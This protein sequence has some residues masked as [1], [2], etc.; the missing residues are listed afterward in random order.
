MYKFNS[1]GINNDKKLLFDK[2]L[3]KEANK[4]SRLLSCIRRIIIIP[5]LSFFSK[6]FQH[7]N[8]NVKKI[9]TYCKYYNILYPRNIFFKYSNAGCIFSAKFCII[10][11]KFCIHFKIS[12]FSIH[13]ISFLIFSYTF[14]KEISLILH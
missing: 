1:D 10:Y 8:Y 7:I 5:N 9:H 11:S 3:T 14:F 2:L 4:L 13:Y 6:F 12:V